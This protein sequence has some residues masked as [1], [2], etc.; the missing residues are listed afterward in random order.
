[1]WGYDPSGY[2]SM[3]GWGGVGFLFMILWWFI[4]IAGAI[5]LLRWFSHS[6]DGHGCRHPGRRMGYEHENSALDILKER[7]AKGEIDKDEFE[8]KKKDLTGN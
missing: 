8:A 3:M 6:C 2:G 5:A 7:Y 4:I 1:M